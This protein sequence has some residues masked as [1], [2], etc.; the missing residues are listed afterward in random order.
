MLNFKQGP[1]QRSSG[2]HADEQR[3]FRQW[4]FCKNIAHLKH[5]IADQTAKP[6]FLS[7]R[8]LAAFLFFLAFLLEFSN[9]S[10]VNK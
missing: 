9:Q 10:I 2:E 6:V 1:G 8:S 3:W 5:L 7:G 4:S